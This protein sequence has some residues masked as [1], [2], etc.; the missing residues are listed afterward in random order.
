MRLPDNCSVNLRDDMPLTIRAMIVRSPD[1]YF[2]IYI[3]A[4]LS[5]AGQFT[6]LKHELRHALRQ[7]WDSDESIRVIEADTGRIRSS[8]VFAL[9]KKAADLL[10]PP[11][12]PEPQAETASNELTEYQKRILLQAMAALDSRIERDEFWQTW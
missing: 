7:D 9:L 1:D 2:N 8:N 5:H 11:P 10:P 12:E 6:S 4:K 3:N